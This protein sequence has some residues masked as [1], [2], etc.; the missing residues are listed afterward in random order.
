MTPRTP[1]I[2]RDGPARLL[3]AT[4][5]LTGAA[6]AAFALA[7]RGSARDEAFQGLVGGLGLGPTPTL[8]RCDREFDPRA[9]GACA[10]RHEPFPGCASCPA[11]AGE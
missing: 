4:L 10:H 9:Y 11:H 1:R 8:G 2:G 6:A 3:A 5:L 7:G